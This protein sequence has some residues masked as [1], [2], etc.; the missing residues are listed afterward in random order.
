M[1]S[2]VETSLFIGFGQKA[3]DSSTPLRSTRNDKKAPL[4]MTHHYLCNALS[5][6]KIVCRTLSCSF[7]RFFT[8]LHACKT[9]P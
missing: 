4:E 1:S 8:S 6:K 9:V 2:E 5:M 7:I 3:R